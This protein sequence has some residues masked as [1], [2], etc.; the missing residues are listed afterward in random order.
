VKFGFVTDT[1]HDPIKATDTSQGGKYYQD[2][3][4][5][6]TDITAVFNA[7][8]DLAFVV[9]N[10]DFIDGAASASAALTDLATINNALNVNVPKHHVLG[11]HEVTRLR[12]EQVMS[13]TGQP[14]KWYSFVESG[15]TFIVLDGNFL[16]DDDSN[17]LSVSS[18]QAGVSPYKSYI[19]PAQRAWLADTI[20]AS[21]YKCVIICHYPVYYVGAFSWGLTNAA[22]VRKIL[23]SF[24]DKVIGCISGHLHDNFIRR[25]NGILYA[26]LHATTTG[27]YPKLNYAIISVY[28]RTREIRIDAHGYQMSHVEA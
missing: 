27:A 12:K 8:D 1:H 19:P 4:N 7:R 28:P 14:G 15:V 25:V 22:A 10:G 13:V 6:I 21:P 24:G 3:V 16:S 18:S 2:A 17:D 5:K 11:N 20:A 9:Q 23:E 26:T